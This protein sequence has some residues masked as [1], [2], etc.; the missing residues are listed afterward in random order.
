MS[1]ALYPGSFDPI[2]NGHVDV[3]EEAAALFDQVILCAMV[4]PAKVDPL[5]D[6]D[7]RKRMLD[8][9]VAHVANAR[10]EL[11]TGLAVDA[12]T[13]LGADLIVKGL[14]TSTDFEYETQMALTNRAVTGVRTVFLPANP[15]RSF[16]TST[17]IR[18]IARYGGD[19]SSLVPASVAKLLE[20]RYPR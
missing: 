2:H 10:V 16:V 5:F 14:R 1:I 18:E 15:A 19:V 9:A 11:Y 13:D 6:L 17:F 4:N 7:T 3:V 12:V 8:D 20:E